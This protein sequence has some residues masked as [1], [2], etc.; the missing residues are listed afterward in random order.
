MLGRP[1]ALVSLVFVAVGFASLSAA[2]TT[3]ED[4]S[5]AWPESRWRDAVEKVR[6]GRRLVPE[7][8]ADGAKVAVA[9]SFDFDATNVT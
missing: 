8:W 5:W 3:E 2:Q 1:K 4:P 7:S 9:L 6:S